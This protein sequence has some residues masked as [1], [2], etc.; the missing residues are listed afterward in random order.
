MADCTYVV[1]VGPKLTEAYRRYLSSSNKDV[2]EF[3]P[4]VFAD[5]SSVQQV[6]VK[7]KHCNVLVFGR[8]DAKDFE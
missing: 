1:G 3:T 5:F 2:F 6:P 7:R 8:G 4:G